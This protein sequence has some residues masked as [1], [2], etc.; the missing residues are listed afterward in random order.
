MKHYL[1]S[2]ISIAAFV[3]T[4]TFR[5]AE[6]AAL[7]A[8]KPQPTT[9]AAAVAVRHQEIHDAIASLRIARDYLQHAAHDF[10]GHREE[11]IRKI[12]ESLTQLQLCQGYDK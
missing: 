8:P 9:S 3:L 10:G 7:P 4:I 1:V 6:P 11:A 5:V 2:V 12:D